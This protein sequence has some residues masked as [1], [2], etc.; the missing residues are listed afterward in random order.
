MSEPLT[1]VT[2]ANLQSRHAFLGRT[3]GVSGGLFHSLNTGLGSSDQRA[4]VLVNRA[5]AAAAMGL[6]HDDLVT[7]H[8]VHGT[9][10]VAAGRWP[11]DGRPPADA[12]VTRQP[13]L[14]LGILTAD[15]APIL[16]EDRASG[17]VAA[18]HAGWKGALGGIIEATI[19]AMEEQGASRDQIAA[20][21]GPCIGAASY[22]VDDAFAARFAAADPEN[23]RFFHPGR[24]GHQ[25]FA[26]EAYCLH[27]LQRAGIR[28]TRGVGI[29]TCAESVRFF[30]YRRAT[31]QGEPDY[32]RQIS[33]I[34]L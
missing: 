25:F 27:R 30:S 32:G 9:T 19:A 31:L 22:E 8:Q 29:D 11:L 17:V 7:V 33:L 1:V 5:A 20:A 24:P 3:G 16:L 21:V 13:G 15:C 10:A 12:I 34:R 28:N 23:R 14:A 4:L 26:L 18:T 2:A 6:G